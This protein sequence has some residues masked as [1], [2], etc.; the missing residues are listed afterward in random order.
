[1]P[2]GMGSLTT[3]SFQTHRILHQFYIATTSPFVQGGAQVDVQDEDEWE[4]HDAT[5]QGIT[6]IV[7]STKVESPKPIAGPVTQVTPSLNDA[8]R[9]FKNNLGAKVQ[10]SLS[11]KTCVFDVSKGIDLTTKLTNPGKVAVTLPIGLTPCGN[12]L[13]EWMFVVRDTKGKES[14]F[15]GRSISR[16]HFTLEELPAD[17]FITLKPGESKSCATN[18]GG[19]YD[20]PEGDVFVRLGPPPGDPFVYEMDRELKFTVKGT[21]AH[22]KLIHE[23]YQVWADNQVSDGVKFKGTCT[24]AQKKKIQEALRISIKWAQKAA[25][26]TTTTNADPNIP[27]KENVALYYGTGPETSQSRYAESVTKTFKNIL[28][29]WEKTTFDCD[30]DSAKGDEI[31]KKNGLKPTCSQGPYGYVYGTRA[32]GQVVHLCPKVLS[33][34]SADFPANG[35]TR[36]EQYNLEMTL[37]HELSHFEGI[38]VGPSKDG[39]V[40]GEKDLTVTSEFGLKAYGP[41]FATTL[42]REQPIDAMNNADNLSQFARDVGIGA[43]M[44]C[45]T[46]SNPTCPELAALRSKDWLCTANWESCQEF[47]ADMNGRKITRGTTCADHPPSVQAFK[48]P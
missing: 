12:Y 3:T 44:G 34:S 27:C 7:A 21:A 22:K 24:D 42:G 29:E 20:V 46:L 37:L 4:E 30:P 17:Q 28:A 15:I 5:V 26:C 45:D 39:K 38:G 35:A 9:S 43:I 36:D 33:M 40:L 18:I 48:K 14:A 41:M 47:C 19:M 6:A 1:M 11:C 23:H 25:A 8:A 32:E 13:E 16:A 10:A 2:M 31:G